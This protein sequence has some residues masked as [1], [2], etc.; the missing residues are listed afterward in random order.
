MKEGMEE[1]SPL[2]TS[3]DVKPV[4]KVVVGTVAG[5]LH[6][7]GKNIVKML[8]SSVGFAVYDLGVDVSAEQFVHEIKRTEADIVAMSALLTTTM[9][10]MKVTIEEVRK[11]GL[12]DKVK[13]IVG[14]CPDN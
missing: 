14:G 4:G 6:D 11:A 8:L 5:D 7:I 2:L 1:I 12:R 9:N 13:I 3:K 10:S